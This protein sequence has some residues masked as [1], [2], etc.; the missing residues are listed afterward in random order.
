MK[1]YELDD[2]LGW[3]E[4]V[5]RKVMKWMSKRTLFNFTVA[6]LCFLLIFI[7]AKVPQLFF[8]AWIGTWLIVIALIRQFHR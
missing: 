5:I 7:G 6:I 4:R 2:Y 1:E 8:L 3:L